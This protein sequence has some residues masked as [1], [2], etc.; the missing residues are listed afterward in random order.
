MSD[1]LKI[2]VKGITKEDMDIILTKD[3]Y[4]ELQKNL[5]EGWEVVSIKTFPV[6]KNE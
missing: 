4:D 1:V 5:P 2:S 6:R 3:V